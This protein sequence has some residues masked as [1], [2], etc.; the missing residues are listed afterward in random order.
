M[1]AT[2]VVEELSESAVRHID[3]RCGPCRDCCVM[4]CKLGIG[5]LIYIISYRHC[6]RCSQ[7]VFLLA[8]KLNTA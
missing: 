3:R 5:K 4:I 2:M 7:F 1:I 8:K 6:E